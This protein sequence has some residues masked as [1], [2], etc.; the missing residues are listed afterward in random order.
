MPRG[1]RELLSVGA[2]FVINWRRLARPLA[3]YTWP[4]GAEYDREDVLAAQLR[5]ARITC[6]AS[7]S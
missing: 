5:S 4:L 7:F 3:A 1:V 6:R 2:G